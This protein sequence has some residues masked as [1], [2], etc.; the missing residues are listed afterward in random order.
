MLSVHLPERF[1]L[2][3]LAGEVCA[4]LL[5]NAVDNKNRVARSFLISRLRS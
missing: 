5:A 3:S 1:G 2:S 4:W